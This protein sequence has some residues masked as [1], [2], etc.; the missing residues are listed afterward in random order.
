M[1]GATGYNLT[2]MQVAPK[3]ATP[4]FSD[5]N[6][7][8]TGEFGIDQ[9]SDTLRAD[10]GSKVTAYGAREGTGSI[11]FAS[12]DLSTIAVMTGDAFST[13]GTPGT[14]KIDRLE[15]AGSTTPPNLVL[16]AWVPNV[17]GNTTA[18]GMR[19]TVAN[20]T[21]SVPSTSFEQ[22]SWTEF[23]S[24]LSYVSNEDDIML[25]W[26]LLDAAP[27]FTG[28]VIPVQLAAPTP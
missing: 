4:V 12:A 10:G 21:L 7:A 24:D 19:I 18:A 3:G 5:V 2:H 20:G 22:E 17:D 6:Y 16:S 28:G 8:T 26:E 9:D 14:D 1:A 25:I 15:I 23:E 27:T 13:S 11:G